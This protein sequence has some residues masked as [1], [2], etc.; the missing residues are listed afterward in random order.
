MNRCRDM[1]IRNFC[2]RRLAAIIDL[3]QSGLDH[4]IRQTWSGLDDPLQ[5]YGRSKFS[6]MQGRSS[7]VNIYMYIDVMYSSLLASVTQRLRLRWL[8]SNYGALQIILVTYKYWLTTLLPTFWLVG[9]VNKPGPRHQ[10]RLVLGVFACHA[11]LC[12][13]SGITA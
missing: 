8:H 4:S 12:S 1:A 13:A 7:V 10:Q 2:R 5:R 3:I 6:K 11:H 9:E